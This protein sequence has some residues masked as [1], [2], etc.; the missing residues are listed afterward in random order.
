MESPDEPHPHPNQLDVRPQGS[1]AEVPLQKEIFHA[2]KDLAGMTR[3]SCGF[4]GL[5]PAGFD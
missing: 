4:R 5:D 2:V 3:L 1:P